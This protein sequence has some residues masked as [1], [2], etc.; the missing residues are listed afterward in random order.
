MV[1]RFHR[2]VSHANTCNIK[3]QEKLE[4][5]ED[6]PEREGRQNKVGERGAQCIIY[7]CMKR[8]CVTLYDEHTTNREKK[9][10][11]N[12]TASHKKGKKGEKKGGAASLWCGSED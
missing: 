7:S 4:E 1:P 8:C 6:Q 11:S 3:A 12:Y 9:I 2:Y 5:Q 10:I